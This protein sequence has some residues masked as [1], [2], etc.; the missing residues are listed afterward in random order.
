MGMEGP[1]DPDTMAQDLRE[2]E[3]LILAQGQT[4][5]VIL[6]K[7]LNLSGLQKSFS[8]KVKSHPNEG[9]TLYL[10]SPLQHVT[11]SSWFWPTSKQWGTEIMT[12]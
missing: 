5:C 9:R 3:I 1:A 4:C 12:L 6:G 2:S 11:L 10:Q 8:R 7:S